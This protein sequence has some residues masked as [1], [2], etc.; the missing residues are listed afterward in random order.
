VNVKEEERAQVRYEW[1]RGKTE[2]YLIQLLTLLPPA[3]DCLLIN[4][5]ISLEKLPIGDDSLLM[6]QSAMRLSLIGYHCGSSPHFPQV[7]LEVAWEHSGCLRSALSL[8][9]DHH[10]SMDI[11]T[12]ISILECVSSSQPRKRKRKKRGIGSSN[13]A[14]LVIKRP[15]SSFRHPHASNRD[16]AS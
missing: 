13:A 6:R 10:S 3:R 1:K 16:H 5:T 8:I 11:Y 2:L 7:K 14:P 15:R 9:S 12:Y 4:L